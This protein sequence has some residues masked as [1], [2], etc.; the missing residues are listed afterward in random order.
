MSDLRLIRGASPSRF[1]GVHWFEWKPKD[2][3]LMGPAAPD[4]FLLHPLPHDGS[5]FNTIAPCLAAGRT[6][7]APDYPGCGK[8]DSPGKEPSME[9]YA[10]A[11][12]DVI[13]ARD[14]H[15][16][17]DLLGFQSGCPVAAQICRAYPSE[18]DRVI[19]VDIP[20]SDE[21]SVYSG[22]DHPCL[23]VATDFESDSSG[24]PGETI[25]PG[26]QFLEIKDIQPPAQENGAERISQAALK[27]FDR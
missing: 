3:A 16:A 22:I 18:V 21:E 7:I 24:R 5:W 15:G 2:E 12:I 26:C 10:D 6:V 25:V 9:I 8:S 20:A 4:L 19:L 1:G 17:V 14:T 11:M 23:V 13:Q 27:F